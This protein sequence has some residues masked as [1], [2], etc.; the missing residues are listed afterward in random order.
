MPDPRLAPRALLIDLDGVI[1]R[2][3]Q[4]L[5]GA[6]ALFAHLHQHRIPYRLLTNNA[7]LTPRQYQ[8]KL[9]AMGIR[10]P[11]TSVLTSAV[12]TAAYL[13]EVAGPGARVLVVGERGLRNA[14]RA[15]GCVLV[16]R[17]ADYVVAGLDRTVCYP[18]LT[19][20]CLAI[21][22]GATFIGTNPDPAF[23]TEEGLW[24]GAGAIQALLTACTGVRPRV[25]GKP[26]P[27]MLEQALRQLGVAPADALMV[28]DSLLTDVAGG[29]AAGVPTA[30]VL[31]G[32]T[33][34]SDLAAATVRPDHVFRDLAELLAALGAR[35]ELLA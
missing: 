20:A 35:H 2:G 9:R 22:A 10:V 34:A 21:A 11:A 31:T 28:G 6:H 7:T 1:Y 26:Q 15:A 25:I 13:R 19:A 27:T 14:L 23:P 5:P 30:L 29:R 24:P 18:R 32:V 16:D 33:R 4:V 3:R 8:A 17:Q 12:A